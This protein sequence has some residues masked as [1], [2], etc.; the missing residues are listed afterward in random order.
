MRVRPGTC[1]GGLVAVLV[2][3]AGIE[4][5]RALLPGRPPLSPWAD[6]MAAAE[7]HAEHVRDHGGA[8]V[9]YDGDSGR[10]VALL[11]DDAIVVLTK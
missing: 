11:T 2:D 3:K 1:P 9:I 10:P 4:L 8:A 6:V 7:T 5:G